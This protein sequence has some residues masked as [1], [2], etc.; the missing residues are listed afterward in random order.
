MENDEQIASELAAATTMSLANI[1]GKRIDT[2]GS[3]VAFQ[4]LAFELQTSS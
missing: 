2:L 4:L 3:F 1:V